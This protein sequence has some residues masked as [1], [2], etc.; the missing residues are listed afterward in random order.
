MGQESG[1]T[2]DQYRTVLQALIEELWRNYPEVA[3]ELPKATAERNRVILSSPPKR[4]F[5][6]AAS[7]HETL[8]GMI[9]EKLGAAG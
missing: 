5:Y 1:L 6:H 2:L 9:L 3:A 8:Q 7:L 4:A